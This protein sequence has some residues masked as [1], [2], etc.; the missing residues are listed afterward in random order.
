MV[1]KFKTAENG[2]V[3]IYA[4][5]N[6][7]F[8]F[9]VLEAFSS[10]EKALAHAQ[11]D[12][13]ACDHSE[14]CIRKLFL[15]ANYG[16]SPAFITASFKCNGELINFDYNASEALLCAWFPDIASE[17]LESI[18]NWAFYIDIPVPFKRG[19]LLT[20]ASPESSSREVFVLDYLYKDLPNFQEKI[21]KGTH[22]DGTD[23]V[24]WAYFIE[25][26]GMLYCETA[27]AHDTFEY[28]HGPLSG[29]AQGLHYVR[30]YLTQEID[31]PAFLALQSKTLAEHLLNSE[32]TANGNPFYRFEELLAE[33]GRPL[34]P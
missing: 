9:A 5:C 22:F 11:L 12:L 24:A 28:Y 29:A 21:K 3:Y 10:Y 14:I 8:T 30:L 23:L 15:D 26:S 4:P 34:A 31:L 32:L 1:E 6:D 25:P 19:D 16:E 7:P 33:N 17:N 20:Y 18:L 27:H 2:A 13:D